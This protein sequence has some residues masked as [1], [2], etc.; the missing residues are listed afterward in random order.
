[1]ANDNEDDIPK[2]N[3]GS[4]TDIC[5]RPEG[6]KLWRFLNSQDHKL[7]MK[8]ASDLGRPALEAVSSLLLASFPDVFDGSYPHVN[9]FKQM[10]GA[11]TRQ[12]MES[13]GYSYVR[14]NVPLDGAP[15]SRAAKYRDGNT[16][17]FHVWRA[18]SN[19]RNVGVTLERSADKLP[20]VDDGVWV[21]WKAVTGSMSDNALHLS[22]AVGIKDV[23]TAIAAL[24]AEGA[25]ATVVER[26][27]RA[28]RPN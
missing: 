26:L 2:F 28:G 8:V 19:T 3:A 13:E 20:K 9:R 21:Y 14:D 22:V 7:R 6:R 17:D 10:A 18:S 5:D 1:M 4:F 27:L 23:T 15:F 24:K 25:Y 12:V 16:V 11:M